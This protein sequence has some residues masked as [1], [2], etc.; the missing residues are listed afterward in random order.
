MFKFQFVLPSI[1]IATSVLVSGCNNTP[2]S[3]NGVL[4]VFGDYNINRIETR[5]DKHILRY[6]R[7]SINHPQRGI[8]RVDPH[9]YE[10]TPAGY[11]E[12]GDFYDVDFHISG[13]GD[14]TSFTYIDEDFPD[15]YIN[16]VYLT[17]LND[18]YL[19]VGGDNYYT[20]PI[21]RIIYSGTN[22]FSV[23]GTER[24]ENGWGSGHSDGTFALEANFALGEGS[25]TG[26]SVKISASGDD[27]GL[28]ESQIEGS[29]DINTEAGTFS[30]G[31]IEVRNHDSNEIFYAYIYGSFHGEEGEAVT[32]IYVEDTSDPLF[33]GGIAGGRV[34]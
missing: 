8:V 4:A 10:F 14:A 23:W 21:G 22:I 5:D 6:G 26:N 2:S 25:I 11:N 1:V 9:S 24:T 31:D 29:F 16:L 12:F 32:G 13:V 27:P 34:D 19:E 18:R 7:S 28:D 20:V 3:T 30:G 17:Y 33:F 15:T